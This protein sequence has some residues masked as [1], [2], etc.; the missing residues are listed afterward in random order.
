MWGVTS[1]YC[2]ILDAVF[3]IHTHASE[4]KSLRQVSGSNGWV[5]RVFLT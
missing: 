1:S 4:G 2:V 3:D 5:S